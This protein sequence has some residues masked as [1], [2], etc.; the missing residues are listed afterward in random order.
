MTSLNE[1]IDTKIKDD[2]INYFEYNEFSN[3]QKIGNGAFG[4]VNRADWKSCGIKVA[5]KILINNPSINE[6]NMNKFLKEL[7]NLRK[8]SFHPNINRCF[9]ITKEP[10]SNNYIMVLQYANQGTLRE[11]LENN[12]ASLQWKDKIQMALDITFGLKCLHSREII[13]RDL[14]AKNILVHNNRLM[15][16]DLGLS[17][18]LTVEVT[19][20]SK[21]YG[22]PAYVEPQCYK[23]D[24]YVRNKKSDIYSLGVLLWEISSGYPPFSTTPIQTLGYKIAIGFREQPI[25]DTPSSYINLY[26]KCWDDNPDLRP[27]IDEIFNILKTVSLEFNTNNEC[28]SEI[29]EDLNKLDVNNETTFTLPESEDTNDMYDFNLSQIEDQIVTSSSP[30]SS[31][32][33]DE[34]KSSTSSSGNQTENQTGT[35]SSPVSSKINENK[36]KPS[37]FFDE[38]IQ[39]YLKYYNNGF[40][41]SFDFYKFLENHN[42]R[43]REIINYFVKNQNTQHY[44]V[45]IGNFHYKGFGIDKNKDMAFKWYV[46]ASQHNDINGY[47]QVG[48]CYH[49]GYGIKKDLK[50]AFKFYQIAANNG[51]NIA[52]Y[53]LAN[54]Y[55]YGYG[56]QKDN[57]KAYELYKKSVENGFIPS[58]YFLAIY[59]EHGLDTQLPVNKRNALKWYKLYQENDG[60]YEVSDKI[61]DIKKELF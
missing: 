60:I 50:K 16:A 40:T 29:A 7:K 48:W 46:Y 23:T 24:D 21:V 31:N 34:R 54:C 30:V 28:Y 14:H 49:Y 1:W 4:I 5:L 11:Y 47:F 39:A 2:D 26:Q 61:R 27:T 10:L 12:F 9:G 8:V 57:F 33:E 17:K 20:I 59:Y 25:A 6:D 18:Q 38:I 41:K 44:K 45:I 13:H 36:R 22:M 19:S 52:L 42:S 32:N 37:Q 58:Q 55:E 3:V 56:I 35:P 51:C 15:I 53:Y 43:S